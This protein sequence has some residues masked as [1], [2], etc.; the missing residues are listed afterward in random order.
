MISTHIDD[1]IGLPLWK[2]L[3]EFLNTLKLAVSMNEWSAAA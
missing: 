2:F 1:G 3:V